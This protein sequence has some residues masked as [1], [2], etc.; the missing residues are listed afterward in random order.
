MKGI[1]QLIGLWNGFL[2]FH[3]DGSEGKYLYIKE[4]LGGSSYSI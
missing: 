1:C 4:I 2:V 3:Q